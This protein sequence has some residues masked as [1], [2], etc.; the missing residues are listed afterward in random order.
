MRKKHALKVKKKTGN[1]LINLY[2]THVSILKMKKVSRSNSWRVEQASTLRLPDVIK[3]S[4]LDWPDLF[5]PF[6]IKKNYKP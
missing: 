2:I 4:L 3:A 6:F 1:L 5:R